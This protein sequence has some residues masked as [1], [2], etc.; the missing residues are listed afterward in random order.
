[1]EHKRLDRAAELIEALD[2]APPAAR[3][4]FQQQPMST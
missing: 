2:Q 1:M 3:S 4:A